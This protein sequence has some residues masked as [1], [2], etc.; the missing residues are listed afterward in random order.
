MEPGRTKITATIEY[1]PEGLLEKAGCA[2]GVPS[3][4]V[5]ADL[6]RFRDFIQDQIEEWRPSTS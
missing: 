3:G 2:L 4:R 1:E 6:E 5:A